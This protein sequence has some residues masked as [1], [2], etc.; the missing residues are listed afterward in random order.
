MASKAGPDHDRIAIC[1]C[2]MSR[3]VAD[4]A[5]TIS[6]PHAH[7][8][9]EKSYRQRYRYPLEIGNSRN[10]QCTYTRVR[11]CVGNHNVHESEHASRMAGSSSLSS[12]AAAD[13]A[14]HKHAFT[15]CTSPHYLAYLPPVTKVT[16]NCRGGRRYAAMRHDRN[17]VLS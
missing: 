1:C 15:S 14:Y 6:Q 11:S 2:E 9:C 4:A 8:I 17:K 13:H 5:F 10:V 7:S 3:C 12:P 16:R